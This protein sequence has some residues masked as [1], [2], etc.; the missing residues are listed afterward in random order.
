MAA[1]LMRM[2]S[3]QTV[4]GGTLTIAVRDGVKVNDATVIQAD[5]ECTNGVIH[6]ID[7]VL[8]PK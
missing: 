4:Q 8:M 2:T 1:D 6:I 3:A 7:S 5:V